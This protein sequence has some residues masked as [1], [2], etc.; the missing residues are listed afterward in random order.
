MSESPSSQSELPD[1]IAFIM[2]GNRRWAKNKG[3]SP[4]DGHKSGYETFKKV[5][6]YCFKRGI[7]VVTVYAFSTENWKRTEEEVGTL[8]NLMRFAFKHE[9]SKFKDR[10]IKV[11]ILGTRDRL[12]KDILKEVESIESDTSD[13]S[14]GVLNI[15]LS[16][17]GKEE[18]IRAV[19]EIQKSDEEL[20]EDNVDKH[21][22]TAG[23]PNPD[24]IVRPGGEHR[25]SNFLLWQ[26][27][28]SE[29][30]FTDTL[31]PDMDEEEIEK[32]LNFYSKIKRNFGR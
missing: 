2:D 6:D 4:L 9:I 23:Q 22:Y 17:G 8:M 30:Y 28:Y 26:S 21:L 25:L 13:R 27:D 11:N 29:L 1:H 31:W 7:K 5:V 16:Y 19:R 18:I 32:I 24:I 20:T 15:A 14:G 12:P 3:I 10:D